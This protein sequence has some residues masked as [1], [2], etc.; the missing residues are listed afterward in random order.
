MLKIIG[1]Q[2]TN[3]EHFDI[4]EGLDRCVRYMV[5]CAFDKLSQLK[6]FEDNLEDDQE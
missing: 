6:L 5:D 2:R 1:E 3:N 4:S